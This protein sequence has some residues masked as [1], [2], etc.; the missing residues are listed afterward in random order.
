MSRR[1]CNEVPKKVQK[2]AQVAQEE[3]E[4][5]VEISKNDLEADPATSRVERKPPQPTESHK[6][7][8]TNFKVQLLLILPMRVCHFQ[9]CFKNRK[10][11]NM[12]KPI[13]EVF[14][15]VQVNIPLIDC[16]TQVPK[17]AKFLK[18]L[19]TTKR[20]TREKEVVKLSE[21]L[22]AV[23]Q[24]KLPPK[25]KDPG[26]FSIPCV[27]GDTTFENVMLDLRASINVMPYSLYASMELYFYIIDME[28]S[29]SSS[30]PI[31]LGRP[32]M[33][34]ARTKIDVYVGAL[35]MEFDGEVIGFNIFEDMRYPLSELKP[36]YSIDIVDSLAQELLNSMID[37]KLEYTISQ[38]EHIVT[39]FVEV[40]IRNKCGGK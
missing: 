14:K 39:N 2:K 7:N 38:V 17:Y 15:K 35:T 3:E 29:P 21:T 1:V 27:I 40:M 12:M 4:E 31:L 34:T 33:R 11:K 10:K 32:F 16:I 22:F 8:D 13:L 25:L 26:S 6:G 24:R 5:E 20:Q 36:C 9:A 30:T 23:L 18:E 19:C 28:D 37:D